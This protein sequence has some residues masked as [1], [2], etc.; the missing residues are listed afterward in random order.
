MPAPSD[1]DLDRLLAQLRAAGPDVD[2]ATVETGFESRVLARVRTE[3]AAGATTWFWRWS[4]L[5]GAL[6]IAFTVVAVQDYQALAEDSFAALA[7][8]VNVTAL[9]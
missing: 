7:S 8:S 9:E 5:F 3:D 6:A 2:P 4:A 1:P